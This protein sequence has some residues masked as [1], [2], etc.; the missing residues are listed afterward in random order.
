M[1]IST[2]LARSRKAL[3]SLLVFVMACACVI[4]VNNSS[5]V[6]QAQV[7]EWGKD[8]GKGKQPQRPQRPTGPDARVPDWHFQS[9]DEEAQQNYLQ[10]LENI[11]HF[12][13]SVVNSDPM[14]LQ[15]ERRSDRVLEVPVMRMFDNN[16]DAGTLRLYFNQHSMYLMGWRAMDG[17]LWQFQGDDL[18]TPLGEPNVRT[19]PFGGNYG[20][21]THNRERVT[22][23]APTIQNALQMLANYSSHDPRRQDELKKAL[24]VAIAFFSEAARFRPIQDQ[25]VDRIAWGEGPLP[26]DDVKLENSWDEI[27]Q[28]VYRYVENGTNR[29]Q[30]FAGRLISDLVTAAAI[31][32]LMQ[33]PGLDE[34]YPAHDD[35]A[36]DATAIKSDL[37][38]KCLDIPEGKYEEGQS[39]IQYTC[40][41]S[42]NQLWELE[43]FNGRNRIRS[44]GGRTRAGQNLCVGADAK[45]VHC[46]DATDWQFRQHHD[47]EP[48]DRRWKLHVTQEIFHDNTCLDVQGGN[49]SDN[50][51]VI[52]YECQD[53]HNQRWQVVAAGSAQAEQERSQPAGQQNVIK[54]HGTNVCATVPEGAY[55]DDVNI[56]FEP[57]EDGQK[58]QQWSYD[59]PGNKRIQSLGDPAYCLQAPPQ[60]GGDTTPANVRLVKCD[61]AV[62]W[63]A[64][65]PDMPKSEGDWSFF[66]RFAAGGDRNHCLQGVAPYENSEVGTQ[67][68]TRPCADDNGRQLLYLGKVI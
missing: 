14:I 25:M 28:W 22:F 34:R 16:P 11:R 38:G 62:T 23:S 8:K 15:T 10:L 30:E 26:A 46:N 5:P 12:V 52:A 36:T 48:A 58:N 24:V 13:G 33:S 1:N 32:V 44:V 61:Q 56:I 4:V 19:L 43:T 42:P 41:N 2:A 21:L 66:S 7:E 55:Q 67:L 9:G 51:P 17:Q 50:T 57:C 64:L 27:S 54:L 20:N 60:V 39:L 59:S 29:A 37:T 45:L 65:G 53:S 63:E 35:P 49:T 40:Q 6:A 18:G 68:Q 47:M 31:I 3:I